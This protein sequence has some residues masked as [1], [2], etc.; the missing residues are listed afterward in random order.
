M[1]LTSPC[2]VHAGPLGAAP[3][4]DEIVRTPEGI[5]GRSG[6]DA[7]SRRLSAVST[8]RHREYSHLVRFPTIH[9][10]ATAWANY[11]PF[12]MYNQYSS[13]VQV[14]GVRRSD[15]SNP[16]DGPIPVRARKEIPPTRLDRSIYTTCGEPV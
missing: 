3:K 13:H 4:L 12:D 14:P 5:S 2:S 15:R 7:K 10:T 6:P 8:K 16:V 1:G 11:A 9:R